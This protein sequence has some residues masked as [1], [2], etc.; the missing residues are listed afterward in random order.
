MTIRKM[1]KKAV[2]ITIGTLILLLPLFMF[3]QSFANTNQEMQSIIVST[4]NTIKLKSISDDFDKDYFDLLN[5]RY[6]G[7]SISGTSR[8][9]NFSNFGSFDTNTYSQKITNYKSFLNTTYFKKSNIQLNSVN[10][11]TSFLIDHYA[12]VM[13]D[14]NLY[15]VSTNPSTI[16]EVY[17]T[18]IVN[19]TSANLVSTDTPV[20]RS[21]VLTHII[22]NDKNGVQ[23]LSSNI[24]VRSTLTNKP[25]SVIF[26]DGSSLEIEL[27]PYNGID[28]TIYTQINN[29]NVNI[30]EFKIKYSTIQNFTIESNST[31]SI[32]SSNSLNL[33]KN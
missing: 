1:N 14:S 5:V 12:N 16:Q 28:G 24:N 31:I 23:L 21:G 9:I 19:Q 32:S 26:N 29:L 8:W 17:L 33:T 13:F 18:A 6:I 7:T 11:Y 20:E 2:L 4:D 3:S 22:I 25:F 10:L 15:F 30:T 27:E